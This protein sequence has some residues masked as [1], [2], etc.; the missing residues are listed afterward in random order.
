MQSTKTKEDM[1]N[2]NEVMDVQEDVKES[3][4]KWVQELKVVNEAPSH[5]VW[6]VIYQLFLLRKS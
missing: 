4:T 1:Y 2:D 6:C 3:K 5:V